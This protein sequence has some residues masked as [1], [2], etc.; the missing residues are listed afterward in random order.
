M[1]SSKPSTAPSR[2]ALF[3]GAGVATAGA[4][5]A[6]V[7]TSSSAQAAPGDGTLRIMS[8]PVRAY[9]S[10]IQDGKLAAGTIR[11]VTL[12]AGIATNSA[13]VANVTVTQGE[14]RGFIT[15]FAG[16]AGRPG[17][18]TVNY[19]K[20]VDVANN[21]IIKTGGATGNTLQ[22]FTSQNAHVII[23]VTGTVE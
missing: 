23:D 19:V 18:S 10:R 13:V 15:V 7:A 2:R 21:A 9:D 5:G 22:I 6:V 3:T 4:V 20:N 1:S 8:N 17:T 11:A 12:P 14:K 16:G